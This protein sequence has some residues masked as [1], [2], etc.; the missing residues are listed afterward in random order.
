VEDA[1]ISNVNQIQRS[2]NVC[3]FLTMFEK[4]LQ[5]WLVSNSKGTTFS[6]PLCRSPVACEPLKP[7][8]AAFVPPRRVEPDQTLRETQR[9]LDER[10]ERLTHMQRQEVVSRGQITRMEQQV[11]LLNNQMQFQERLLREQIQGYQQAVLV[12]S[13]RQAVQHAPQSPRQQRFQ[14]QSPRQQRNAGPPQPQESHC[15]MCNQ[16]KGARSFSAHQRSKPAHLRRCK[17]CLDATHPGRRRN[18]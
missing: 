16:D 8:V 11:Q 3:G 10:T 2:K 9:L 13:P 17:N 5:K 14:T 1:F 7:A 4:G 15:N 18:P 6:C 12:L